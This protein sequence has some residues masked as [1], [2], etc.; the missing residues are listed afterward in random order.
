VFL[1][2]GSRAIF[3]AALKPRPAWQHTKD[4]GHIDY[5]T[6]D[7]AFLLRRNASYKIADRMYMKP[8]ADP[9]LRQISKRL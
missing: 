7:T 9:G 4:V 1:F 3:S 6:R 8:I 5:F 2:F